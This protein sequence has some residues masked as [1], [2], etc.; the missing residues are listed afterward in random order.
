MAIIPIT[1]GVLPV[2]VYIYVFTRHVTMMLHSNISQL[3][4]SA[5][6]SSSSPPSSSS[7]PLHHHWQTCFCLMTVSTMMIIMMPRGHHE[8]LQHQVE[9]FPRLGLAASNCSGFKRKCAGGVGGGGLRTERE[10]G[11]ERER[12]RE[13][14]RE[15][16]TEKEREI[17]R[18]R[19]RETKKTERE[20]VR[21][22]DDQGIAAVVLGD[23]IG[24]VWNSH[25]LLAS[26][27]RGL[28]KQMEATVVF[29]PGV[30]L[31]LLSME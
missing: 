31:F 6:T 22:V 12:Q 26:G 8:V 17:E 23:Y 29:G 30:R 5:S 20:R 27:K 24:V 3:Q 11:T 14:D 2:Y 18:E 19:E 28:N 15:R 7:S 10:R 9:A 16:E 4:T 21:D 25:L 1:K 13:R